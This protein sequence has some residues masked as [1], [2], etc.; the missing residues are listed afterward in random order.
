MGISMG[1][2]GALHTGL[3]YPENYSG[4]IA[5]SSALIAREV[6]NMKEG[7]GNGVADYD[8][9]RSTFGEPAELETSENNPEY[10]VKNR[11][12]KGEAIQPIFMA[13]GTKTSFGEKQAVPGFPEGTGSGHRLRLSGRDDFKCI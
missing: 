2:F 4:I 9:Y 12:E 11:L 8:Y 13:C 7:E 1:G 3:L 10:V 6:M 5:L